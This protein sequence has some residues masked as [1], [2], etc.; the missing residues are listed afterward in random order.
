MNPVYI[1]GLSSFLPNAPVSNSEIESVLGK[2]ENQPA[3]VKNFVLANNGIITRHYAIDPAT[4]KR[5]HS[6]AQLCAEA[7]SKL[8]TSIDLPLGA[9]EGLACGT[10]SA[11]QLIPSHANMVAGELGL[12]PSEIVSTSGVCASGMAAMKY[13]YMSVALGENKNFIATG[14]ERAS[15]FLDK[16]SFGPMLSSGAK[17]VESAPMVTFEKEFLRWMLSDG[18]GAVILEPTPRT[19]RLSLK[20]EHMYLRS[21][22]GERPVCMYAGMNK[23]RDGSFTYWSDEEDRSDLT[24]KGYMLLQQDARVLEQNMVDVAGRALAHFMETR[25]FDPGSIDW[26]LPHLSSMYFKDRLAERLAEDGVEIPE[27]KWFTNLTEKGNTGSASIYIMLDEL[28]R[29]GRLSKGDRIV[30]A[31]PESARFTMAGTVLTV[32]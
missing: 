23:N 6:N 4:G 17:D 31:V 28:Y 30:C 12:P 5:T 2:L 21:W 24:G 29:S 22:A 11:D 19:D 25:D 27:E 13:G 7:V 16:Q 3:R 32:C 9:V 14:S 8:A 26:F 15:A 1:T 20:I 18:A 10:S